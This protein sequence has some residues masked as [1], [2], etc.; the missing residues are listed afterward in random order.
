MGSVKLSYGVMPGGAEKEE[1][2]GDK[3]CLNYQQ[4]IKA[5]MYACGDVRQPDRNTSMYVEQIVY[6]QM[7]MLLDQVQ[8]VS[9]LRNSKSISTED[10]IF[11]LRRNRCRIKKITNYI[12]FK[13]VRNKVKREVV[14]LAG[15]KE[16]KYSWLPTNTYAATDELKE[17]LAAIDRMTES[18]SKD[19]Y[20]DFTECRQASFTFRKMKKFREYLNADCKLKDEIV[21]ILGFV[22]CEIVFDIVS[23]ARVINTQKQKKQTKEKPISGIFRTVRQQQAI[24]VAEIDEA[25]RRLRKASSCI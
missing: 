24:S 17:R 21:D 10:I 6:V 9:R 8:E 2:R 5:M 18:M 19:E 22:A 1:R 12:M 14:A 13:D 15:E 25:C 23:L 3:E 7:K 4:E 20:L 11:V 16:L